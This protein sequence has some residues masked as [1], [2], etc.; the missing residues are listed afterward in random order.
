[1]TSN[2]LKTSPKKN[3]KSAF[4]KV[5]TIKNLG[6]GDANDENSTQGRDFIEQAFSSQ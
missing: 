1:M 5:T 2:D 3:D 4:K 6:G